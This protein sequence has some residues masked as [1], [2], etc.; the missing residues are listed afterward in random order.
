VEKIVEKSILEKVQKNETL[1]IPFVNM[2]RNL[3]AI[4]D[5]ECHRG[6]D[7]RTL[8]NAEG[9][10]DY[11]KIADDE[12]KKRFEQYLK[13]ITNVY[14]ALRVKD[15]GTRFAHWC[16]QDREARIKGLDEYPIYWL[17]LKRGCEDPAYNIHLSLWVAG[18][19]DNT[20]EKA[21]RLW[22]KEHFGIEYTIESL[23]QIRRGKFT[24]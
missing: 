7:P 17:T 19:D 22:V 18:P 24:K 11:K 6:A 21:I 4:A 13:A 14:L 15:D 20:E 8:E 2:L 12:E 9:A 1:H 10:L 3:V 23:R 16:S 5:P